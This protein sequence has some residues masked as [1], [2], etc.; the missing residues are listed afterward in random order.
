MG[1]LVAFEGRSIRSGKQSLPFLTD[2]EVL[3][4]LA[5]AGEMLDSI[6]SASD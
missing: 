3:D 1:N 6:D 2:T 4:R 5:A